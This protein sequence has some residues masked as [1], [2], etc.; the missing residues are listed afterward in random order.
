MRK[1]QTQQAPSSK[2]NQTSV[3]GLS[4]RKVRFKQTNLT[5]GMTKTQNMRLE[6][7]Q[8][9]KLPNKTRPREAQEALTQK[10]NVKKDCERGN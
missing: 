8:K 4:S 7:N 6:F 3:I 9:D 2:R 5:H 1:K 10:K